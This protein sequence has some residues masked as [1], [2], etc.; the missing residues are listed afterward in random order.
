MRCYDRLYRLV[1]LKL[2]RKEGER[3][4]I[5]MIHTRME[6]AV[7]GLLSRYSLRLTQKELVAGDRSAFFYY[8]K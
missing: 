3:R 2:T 7:R 5:A 4:H 6:T 1:C 8:D